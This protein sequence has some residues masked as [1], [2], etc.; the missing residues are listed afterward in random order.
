MPL[1]LAVA[2]QELGKHQEALTTLQSALEVHP[3]SPELWLNQGHSLQALGRAS[4]AQLSY[5]RFMDFSGRRPDLLPQR[6]W[7]QNL[8]T[9]IKQ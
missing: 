1:Y 6:A 7:V 8:F 9:R 5:W 3:E 2:Q 4:E